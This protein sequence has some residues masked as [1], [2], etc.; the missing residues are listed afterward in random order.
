[1]KRTAAVGLK[2]REIRKRCVDM[3]R[4]G[5]TNGWLVVYV[6][7]FTNCI[8]GSVVS[9]V[10]KLT[11]TVSKDTGP[12]SRKCFVRIIFKVFLNLLLKP[13]TLT[14]TSLKH[15]VSGLLCLHARSTGAH[16]I[17]HALARVAMA[18]CTWN[19]HKTYIG[20]CKLYPPFSL[21][22]LTKARYTGPKQL[23]FFLA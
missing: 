1:M 16:I 18:S 8:V 9:N 17:H 7:L 11:I 14:F 21:W 22:I 4:N 3:W 15:Y 12:N 5:E 10:D 2:K 23:A 19:K 6:K 20:L 13:I